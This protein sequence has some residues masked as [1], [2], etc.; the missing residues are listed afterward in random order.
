MVLAGSLV[1]IVNTRLNSWQ[2]SPLTITRLYTGSDGQTHAESVQ[3]KLTPSTI[4]SQA[5]WSE[6]V[7]VSEAQ[8]FRLPKGKVQDWHNPARRQYV[9]TLTG[10]G[11]VEIAGRQRIPLS[12]GRRSAA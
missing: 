12:P 8:F 4:Y 6:P 11:E 7:K 10:K 3:I 2:R 5:E 1:V 9:V